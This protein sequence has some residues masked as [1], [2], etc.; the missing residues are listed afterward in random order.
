MAEP[1]E[2]G[3]LQPSAP[4]DSL[5][6][7]AEEALSSRMATMTDS[8]IG[9]VHEALGLTYPSAVDPMQQIP[10]TDFDDQARKVTENFKG[11][12]AKRAATFHADV[13]PPPD[14]D[15]GVD[16]LAITRNAVNFMFHDPMALAGVTWD[17]EHV[18]WSLATIRD[19]VADHPYRAGLA[20]A[21]TLAPLAAGGYRLM[22]A[23]AIADIAV[24]DLMLAGLVDDTA[25]Y[26][27]LTA[28]GKK[29]IQGQAQ[30]VGKLKALRSA[31]ADGSA[32]ASDRAQ[33]N[34][35]EAFGNTY[36]D[37]HTNAEL[38]PAGTISQWQEKAKT[39]TSGKAVN[40]MME[41]ASN[42]KPDEGTK[43]L[44]ALKDPARLSDLSPGAREFT[45][46]FGAEG[47][48]EQAAML[49]SGFIDEETA[50]KVGDI[51]FSTLRKDSLLFNEGAATN[52]LS[53]VRRISTESAADKGRLQVI[54]IPRTSSPHLLSRSLDEEG[55]TS[56]IKRQRASEHLLKGKSDA[57][58]KLLDHPDD[59]EAVNLI[60]SGRAD[61][62][63][64]KL[65]E[66]SG[67]FIESDPQEL[68]ARS[69]LQQ[70]LLHL[71]YKTLRDVAMNPA[72]TKTREEYEAMS[73]SIRKFMVP[74]DRM[75][76]SSVLRRMVAKSQG[77]ATV[78]E[79]GYV[80]SN[81][82]NELGGMI[83]KEAA[84]GAVD[85]LKALTAIHKTSKCVIAGTRILTNK[86]YL[87]IEEAF[88][89]KDGYHFNLPEETP[90]VWSPVLNTWVKVNASYFSK[91]EQVFKV[92]LKDGTEI[93][94]TSDHPLL[95]RG[96][97][98]KIKDLNVGQ[99][100]DYALGGEFPI[101]YQTINFHPFTKTFEKS[102]GSSIIF[103]EALAELIG[104][105][106]G[107]GNVRSNVKD[108]QYIN[109]TIGNE[110]KDYSLS[111][112]DCL[113]KELNITY[114]ISQDNRNKVHYFKIHNTFLV[115]L[116]KHIGAIYQDKSKELKVPDIVF[117][118]P[119]T[120]ITAFLRGLFDTDGHVTKKGGGNL[121]SISKPLLKDV[122][123]LLGWL[124]IRSAYSKSDD[125][126]TVVICGKICS[127]KEHF[128]LRFSS[129]KSRCISN[130]LQLFGMPRKAHRI[131][132]SIKIR[133]KNRDIYKNRI[134][135]I[136]SFGQMDVYDIC[137]DAPHIFIGD[138]IPQHNT[139]LNPYSHGQNVMGNGVFLSMAGFHPWEPE[140]FNLLRTGWKAVGDWHDA[141]RAGKAIS[142]ITNL[143]SLESKVGGK[144]VNIA[145][146]LMNP[147][148]SGPQGIL[149]MSS[150]EASEGIPILSRMFNEAENHQVLLKKFLTGVQVAAK[151][152][153]P[154]RKEGFIEKLSNM[155]SAED[156]SMK[157][158]Y[159]LHLRQN[160][161][162][163]LAAANE[164]ARRLPMYNTIGARAAG[165]RQL[166]LPWVSF[167]META[168][169]MKNNIM[170]KPFNTMM[171][172][173]VPNLVQAGAAMPFGKSYEQ[174][175]DLKQQNPM[176]AQKSSAIV[177]PF[178]DKNDQLRTMMM[179]LM[180]WS[181]LAPQS[182]AKDANFLEKM[183]M[184][185][186]N[187]FPIVMGLV[188]A[189]TGK[190][191]F[192]EDMPID[193][194]SSTSKMEA[195]ILN[196][197]GFIAPPLVQKY[198][199]NAS[200][201][202][203]TYRLGQD[204][205]QNVNPSTGVTGDWLFDMALSNSPIGLKNYA[206]S[207]MTQIANER[208]G[209]RKVDNYRGDLGRKY[210]AWVRTGNWDNAGDVLRSVYQSFATETPDNPGLAFQ[211][212]TDWK[213]SHSRDLMK[214][215]G[216][217]GISRQAFLRKL[218]ETG[219]TVAPV[220]NEARK[221]Y[222][223]ALLQGYYQTAGSK[224]D[225]RNVLTRGTRRAS[226]RS[227]GRQ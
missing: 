101:Q 207:P 216:L 72:I 138:N 3:L 12:E 155:Y 205:G 46:A 219:N 147:V 143:G 14:P 99:E 80:H 212:Y 103:N 83:K 35:Y 49:D 109:I 223:Q 151:A 95:S 195:A 2:P 94:G 62:A 34:F 221:D 97:P 192:G 86:G 110:D 31:V 163:P 117:K 197:M 175:E 161:L 84:S 136:T 30:Q 224:G 50:K 114:K 70:K 52:R 63:A 162:N 73:P 26:S 100:I 10:D 133:K 111:R 60:K 118:S 217:K 120:V 53:L 42:V 211:L 198:L 44:H 25:S 153:L 66:M 8:V 58:L 20:A 185:L 116:F 148:L 29:L 69:L 15:S 87:K 105:V 57:A 45:L 19:M 152:K 218:R 32:S 220:M 156:S 54:N 190:S 194:N 129:L 28:Q 92:S 75:E 139:A 79:L 93:I 107:D 18:N 132:D 108:N 106:L 119:K 82:F 225:G 90:L 174:I 7:P 91:N 48:A 141:R 59:A 6:A 182:E 43:V 22:K 33:L 71:N 157:F 181:A 4:A 41:M 9:R 76:N 183:P 164:V 56:L 39:L 158:G 168:R 191:S 40:D 122:K 214:N 208:Y 177:T 24:D 126:K 165:W 173:H 128:R 149:D 227:S 199:L 81:L 78:E 196:T 145:E 135:S 222:H 121:T 213:Q 179:D 144:A 36:L 124:G 186:G 23:G 1:L 159:Y 204:L 172:M 13:V 176:W 5:L 37:A 115:K 55:V 188:N 125:A 146:E 112:L 89:F 51:W 180:P 150:M 21:G 98:V 61:E 65:E 171:W 127:A 137:L 201:P 154:G 77:K 202:S 123:I 68:V 88:E 102:G 203:T 113:C 169:I 170:D 38:N 200:A 184:G 134:S 210:S 11:Q 64:K 226:G 27:K 206:G 140:N 187:P 16:T 104:W 130:N 160:G 96:V 193:P 167:P 142:E 215:P 74:L 131:Q 178:R 47:R 85:W 189:V 67:G 166:L 209:A 17:T